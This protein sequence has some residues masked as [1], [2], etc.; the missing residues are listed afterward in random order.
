M[1]SF[2][3]SNLASKLLSKTQGAGEGSEERVP[4]PH[5]MEEEEAQITASSR[6]DGLEA[7]QETP[8]GPSEAPGR[9][10][11]L[12]VPPI[13]RSLGETGLSRDLLVGLLLK[14]VQ[15]RGTLSGFGISDALGL[16]FSLVD[17]LLMDLQKSGMLEVKETD[18]PARSSYS[19]ALTGKGRERAGEEAQASRYVGPA[20]V[21]FQQYVDW[22]LRQSVETV[23]IRR[24]L[25]EEGLSD[26]VLPDGFLDLLGP[27]VNSGKSLF[28]YG[29]PG[30]GKTRIAEAVAELF[31]E[32]FFVPHA[33]DLDGHIMVLYDPVF[34]E[35]L[36]PLE[37]S[38][39]E[40]PPGPT[41]FRDL[42]RHDRRFVKVK[43]PV[44]MAG[45]ELEL[46]QLD[47]R[48]DPFGRT[49]QA[50]IQ[51]KANGGVLVIDDLGRQ[52]VRPRDLLNRWIVPLEHRVDY[53]SL[54]SGKKIA[55][56]F[57]CLVVFSTNIEP[58]EL[59]EEA[60][61][62]RIHYKIRV[63]DPDPRQFDEI[64]S[65]CC[66]EEGIPF[67]PAAPEMVRREF[68]EPGKAIP[69]GCHPRDILSHLRDIALFRGMEPDLSPGLLRQA[70]ESYFVAMAPGEMPEKDPPEKGLT[71]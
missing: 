49:Y 41:L 54:E 66:E 21:P 42:P 57:D 14:T 31:G 48:Y 16:P 46:S 29:D 30:N 40:H 45:A 39:W 64:F 33:V 68:Y 59:V 69:R 12:A 11:D 8:M 28:L 34:H 18:G 6:E 50:P 26:L 10:L 15:Q 55:V 27:A 22:V 20:P 17:D 43:R 25:L 7:G 9:G 58:W 4:S 1:S 23:R 63:S 35:A 67:D 70:C 37:D 62:R 44:A 38:S 3:D 5:A 36:E 56:P 53:L 47:L 24:E 32:A 2:L 13:P 51:L 65:R 60:F 71:P 19:F 52:R 61:L